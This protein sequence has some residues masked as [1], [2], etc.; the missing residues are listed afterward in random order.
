VEVPLLKRRLNLKKVLFELYFKAKIMPDRITWM[1]FK[2]ALQD[3]RY[4]NQPSI[5]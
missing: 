5:D 4:P 2:E 3:Y 1:K